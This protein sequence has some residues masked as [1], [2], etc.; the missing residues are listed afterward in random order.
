[1]N[2]KPEW[3]DRCGGLGEVEL[4]GVIYV[5]DTCDGFGYLAFLPLPHIQD[6][7]LDGNET[8]KR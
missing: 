5:C 7:D 2:R 8:A 4:D 6:D 3:C 1:M